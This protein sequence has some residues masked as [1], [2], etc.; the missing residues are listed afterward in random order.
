MG[1]SEEEQI[2]AES[3]DLEWISRFL[4]SLEKGNVDHVMS[5]LSEDVML[6][7]DGGGNVNS[8]KRPIQSRDYVSRILASAF[9]GIKPYYQDPHFEVTALNGETGILLCSVDKIVAAIFIQIQRRKLT[10]I[11]I[12]R[13]PDKLT[14]LQVRCIEDKS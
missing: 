2:A 3:V 6:F 7:S 11:Y 1:I 14:R 12:V 13:N 4:I 8:F 10:R 5:L 9:T